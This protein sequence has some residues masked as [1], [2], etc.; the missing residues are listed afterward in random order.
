MNGLGFV[1]VNCIV[2]APEGTPV[3]EVNMLVDS[4]AFYPLIPPDLARELRIVAEHEVS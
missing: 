3:K 2:G 1:P 4:G